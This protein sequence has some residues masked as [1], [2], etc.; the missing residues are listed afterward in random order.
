MFLHMGT[1]QKGGFDRFIF[2]PK[3]HVKHHL[4]Y[5]RSALRITA[6]EDQLCYDPAHSLQTEFRS[7]HKHRCAVRHLGFGKRSL[8]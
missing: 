6:G 8:Y 7:I 2:N 5:L 4:A 3:P 1:S